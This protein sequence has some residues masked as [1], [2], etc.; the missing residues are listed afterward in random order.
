[1]KFL[2]KLLRLKIFN[3]GLRIK[4][5]MIFIIPVILTMLSLSYF[6]I[7]NER[8]ELQALAEANAIQMSDVAFASL[9]HAMEMNDKK[10][11]NAVFGDIK[12]QPSIVNLRIVS[13][14]NDVYDSTDS[15]EIGKKY[16]LSQSGCMEC[17][18]FTPA[19]RPHS[20]RLQTDQNILR[21]V[22]IIKNGPECQ[23]C[24]STAQTHLGVFLIDTSL[25]QTEKHLQE[26]MIFSIG[27][28]II[29]IL[30]VMVLAYLL[31]QWLIVRR[32]EV[33]RSALM[34]LGTRDF[35]ARI[36]KDWHTKDELTQLG[37]Y[38][39]QIVANLE[40]LQAENDKKERVRSLAIIEERAA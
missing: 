14:N 18:Q 24:H 12:V 38:F 29:S 15:S 10:M 21:V 19:N 35:S 22:S 16:E 4:I 40:A 17:H 20:M 8:T 26:D 3:I 11:L 39:N 25:A 7:L 2:D 6:H 33:I 27:I 34:R 30:V 28:S 5:T 9:I 1:M 13:I 36:T 23:N 37:D 31:I 32:V